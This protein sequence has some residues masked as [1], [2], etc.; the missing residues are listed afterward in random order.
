MEPALRLPA[1][2]SLLGAVFTLLK[3]AVGAGLLSL[4]WAFHKVGEW[5]WLPFGAGLLGLL[6]QRAGEAT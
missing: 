4:P 6:D 1:C 2:L 5:P 3:S